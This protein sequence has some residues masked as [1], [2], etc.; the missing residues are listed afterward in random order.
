[1]TPTIVGVAGVSMNT[2]RRAAAVPSNTSA[3][4]A[5]EKNLAM[6]TGTLLILKETS[7]F[8]LLSRESGMP[9]DPPGM[10]GI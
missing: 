2:T 1:M 10:D 6:E 4:S 9:A 3:A 5:A 8:D 7:I